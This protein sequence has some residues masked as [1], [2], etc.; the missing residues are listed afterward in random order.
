VLWNVGSVRGATGNESR[1]PP[2]QEGQEAQICAA[3][4]AASTPPAT[5]SA[6]SSR[7]SWQLRAA[8]GT[9]GCSTGHSAA[10][11]A[12]TCTRRPRKPRSAPRR[13]RSSDGSS[14]CAVHR[15]RSRP[16]T[17]RRATSDPGTVWRKGLKSRPLLRTA[18]AARLKLPKVVGQLCEL[19]GPPDHLADN[20]A[21]VISLLR[22]STPSP[23]SR[24]SEQVPHQPCRR[25]Y[26]ALSI[27]APG[28]PCAGEEADSSLLGGQPTGGAKHGFESQRETPEGGRGT[29]L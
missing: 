7:R 26:A 19:L 3:P 9:R 24:R 2:C 5:P 29:H 17:R 10:G 21:V 13:S 23:F 25:P 1:P 22:W 11:C 12:G 18:R 16:P 14:P 20:A 27:V 28:R 8:G 6:C 15:R 4:V